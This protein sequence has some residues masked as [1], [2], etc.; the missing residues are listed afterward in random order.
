M[1]QRSAQRGPVQAWRL[2]GVVGELKD[3]DSIGRYRDVV[4]GRLPWKVVPPRGGKKRDARNYA[5]LA[6]AQ[7][8][9]RESISRELSARFWRFLLMISLHD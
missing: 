1:I 9:I 5:V 2:D 8:E 4:L 7:A 6:N 3:G